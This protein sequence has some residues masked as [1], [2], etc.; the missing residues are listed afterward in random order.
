MREIL[1]EGRSFIKRTVSKEEALKIF[2][3]NKYKVELINNLDNSA[4][5]NLYDQKK[6]Y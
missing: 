6:F 1:T 3:D 2:K 4:E 5:I